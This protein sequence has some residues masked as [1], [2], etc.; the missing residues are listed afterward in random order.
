MNEPS[1]ETLQA[2]VQALY[3][4][5]AVEGPPGDD[6]QRA[7]WHLCAEGAEL[8][9]FVDTQGRLQRQELTLL[10]EHCIW[11]SGGGLRTGRVEQGGNAL[12]R[13]AAAVVHADSDVVPARLLRAAHALASYEGE[14]RYI[15]HMQRVLALAREGIE[16]SGANISVTAAR[17][18]SPRAEPEAA[19]T[20][21]APVESSPLP[22]R[23]SEGLVMVAVFGVALVLSLVLFVYFFWGVT[24]PPV[25]P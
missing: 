11:T 7:V 8:L 23:R 2:A 19:P 22:A 24:Q 4:V 20:E 15:L 18:E 6:G 14:D 3:Q 17:A 1:P 5:R 16:M 12:A 13:T 25:G 10:G 21:A 9:S